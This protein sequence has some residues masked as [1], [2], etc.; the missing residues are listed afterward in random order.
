MASD[1]SHKDNGTS[2]PDEK[3]RHES[4]DTLENGAAPPY[5][6]P[7]YTDHRADDDRADE[8]RGRNADK[9]NKKYWLSVNYIGSLFAVGLAFMGGI[10]GMSANSS[11]QNPPS[12]RTRLTLSSTRLWPHRSCSH[13][14]QRGYR[15]L[16]QH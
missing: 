9:Y 8:A 15:S 11:C 16:S 3:D 14:N 13:P 12:R 6:D 5:E 10:G 7:G 4:V 2:S 1:I